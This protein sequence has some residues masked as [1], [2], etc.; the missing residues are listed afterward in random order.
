MSGLLVFL[1]VS[2][3]WLMQT[4]VMC[5]M[6]MQFRETDNISKRARTFSVKEAFES[7]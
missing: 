6:Y 4:S 3:L 1:S 7:V 2:F 5:S